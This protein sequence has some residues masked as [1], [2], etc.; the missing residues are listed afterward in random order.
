MREECD[1]Q[2][3]RHCECPSSPTLGQWFPSSL[4]WTDA[5]GEIHPAGP[6]RRMERWMPRGA[7]RPL[8]APTGTA[9]SRSIPIAA[10]GMPEGREALHS[11]PQC[12]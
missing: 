8:K 11:T 5:P 12:Q 10:L 2:T 9:Y 6:I 4:A 1:T 3:Y 7:A